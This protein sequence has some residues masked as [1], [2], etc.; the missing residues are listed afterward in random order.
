M[1][2][3][4]CQRIV[5]VQDYKVGDSIMPAYFSD[6]IM[7]VRQQLIEVMREVEKPQV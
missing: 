6:E 2:T 3:L 1:S 4:I 5:E 7:H